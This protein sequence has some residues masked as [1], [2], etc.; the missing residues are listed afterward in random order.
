MFEKSNTH[1][2]VRLEREL[3]ELRRMAQLKEAEQPGRILKCMSWFLIL[4][5]AIAT[6]SSL[7]TI[8][9]IFSDWMSQPLSQQIA[10]GAFSLMLL[11][12]VGVIMYLC[13][14]IPRFIRYAAL[15]EV[16]Q[17]NVFDAAERAVGQW[18]SGASYQDY[19]RA[20]S[21]VSIL[22]EVSQEK[23]TE[24][25]LID[26]LMHSFTDVLHHING[27]ERKMEALLEAREILVALVTTTDYFTENFAAKESVQNAEVIVLDIERRAEQLIN[28]HAAE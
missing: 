23:R 16:L 17:L 1:E 15:V 22:D 12:L 3:E 4:M 25:A 20:Q 27:Q 10:N 2:T 18:A 26:R 28:Q 13:F 21:M 5:G 7:A 11:A 8:R 24:I 19:V 6:V 14:V 9:T